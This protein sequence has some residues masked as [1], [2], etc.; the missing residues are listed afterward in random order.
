MLRLQLVLRRVCQPARGLAH[1]P[2]GSDVVCCN[3]AFVIHV[4]VVEML[5]DQGKSALCLLQGQVPVMCEIGL[6]KLLFP[7]HARR[8]T[9]GLGR[10]LRKGRSNQER[11][12]Q[13]GK[14]TAHKVHLCGLVPGQANGQFLIKGESN[15][16]S[17][18]FGDR[19]HRQRDAFRIDVQMRAG[20][21]A[22]GS[23]GRY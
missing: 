5:R 15:A 23:N 20:T 2:P 19:F 7:G 14:D 3:I 18:S 16:L 17:H 9:I 4:D 1:N 22:I 11:H 10:L 6:S 8:V 13:K 12:Y 21:D